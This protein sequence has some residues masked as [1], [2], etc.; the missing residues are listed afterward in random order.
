M[1]SKQNDKLHTRLVRSLNFVVRIVPV[2]FLSQCAIQN[3]LLTVDGNAQM[4][5]GSPYRHVS[6]TRYHVFVDALPDTLCWCRVKNN[7]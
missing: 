5:K 3:K 6:S 1:K 2:E 4:R 7:L